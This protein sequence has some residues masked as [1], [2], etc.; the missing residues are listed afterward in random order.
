MS[1]SARPAAGERV[2][3]FVAI[4]PPSPVAAH[5]GEVVDLLEVSRAN[6]PGRSTRVTPRERWHVTLAFIGEVPER[7]VDAALGALNLVAGDCAPR[8]R[9]AG[10]GTFGR[11]QSTILWVGLDGEV[12]ALRRLAH[13]VRD[14]LRRARLPFD[15]KSFR[16]H[17]TIS[18]PG[19]RVPSELVAADVVTLSQYSG[20]HWTAGELHLYASETALTETGP[21][22]RYTRLGTAPIR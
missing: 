19:V 8:I 1:G 17:L 16:P 7:R 21:Q 3:L 4:D 18:R 13:V 14:Q 15:R 10:G 12:P 22:P 20:P 2:R 11:G 5:L 9:F 6:A